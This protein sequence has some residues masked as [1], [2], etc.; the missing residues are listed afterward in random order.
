MLWVKPI[1]V[2]LVYCHSTTTAKNTK[3]SKIISFDFNKSNPSPT[4]YYSNY[5]APSN[6]GKIMKL[7]PA[8]DWLFLA[9]CDNAGNHSD[10][11]LRVLGKLG[12]K[13][14]KINYSVKVKG[15]LKEFDVID[16]DKVIVLTND[17]NI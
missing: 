2:L 11:N 16:N 10:V 4:V 15:V 6:R 3:K 1:K 9:E 5:Q 13:S 12:V 17:N 8:Q 14:P 7:N